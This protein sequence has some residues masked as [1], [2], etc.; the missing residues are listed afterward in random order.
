[1]TNYVSYECLKCNAIINI[2]E[3]LFN[4]ETVCCQS[5]KT[6]EP[7]LVIELQ[8]ESSVPK[9]F[10][11]GQEITDKVRVSFDWETKTD[12]LGGTRY[13]IEHYE[14]GHKIPTMKGYGLS[15]GKYALD[16]DN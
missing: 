3:S 16:G 2:P 5:C 11:Q 8:N 4:G 6:N 12:E 10:Y 9:V 14:S 1:L 13:N 15:R 7:L